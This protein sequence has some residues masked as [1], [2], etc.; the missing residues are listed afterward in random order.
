MNKI[1]EIAQAWITSFNPTEDQKEL[2]NGRY[3]ICLK[4]EF[5]GES[6]PVTGD[7]YCKKCL[8]PIQKKIFTQKINDSCPL[9]K[10]DT[11]ESEFRKNKIKNKKHNII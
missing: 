2:A 9:N 6:R 3:E 5:Y 8:C 7:E 1:K 10:W 4:C 11:V